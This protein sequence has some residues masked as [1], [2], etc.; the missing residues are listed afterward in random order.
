LLVDL[1]MQIPML[2]ESLSDRYL[3]H[4]TISRHLSQD[5]PP[6]GRAPRSGGGD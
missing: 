5:E 6:V 3:N 1:S 2:S 4:A